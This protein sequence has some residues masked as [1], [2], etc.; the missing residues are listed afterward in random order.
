MQVRDT[1]C[2]FPIEASSIRVYLRVTCVC[3]D[4]RRMEVTGTTRDL[5]SE[6]A[7]GQVLRDLRE[8]K[9]MTLD[10]VAAKTKVP[11][12]SL[13]LIEEDDF[14]R[15]PPDVYTTIYLKA[16][17]KFFGI[18]AGP[19]V[20]HFRDQRAAHERKTPGNRHPVTTVKAAELLVAP[21][22]IRN[23][24]IAAVASGLLFSIAFQ[25][26]KLISPPQLTVTDPLDGTVTE[27]RSVTINGRTEPEVS[28][29]IN[30]K[31][32]SVD[33]NGVFH[34]TFI[35]QDGLNSIEVVGVKKYSRPM[36]VTRN[37]IVAAPP[38]A[39]EVTA[40]PAPDASPEVQSMDTPDA[41]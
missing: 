41:H 1:G 21:R 11:L 32:V 15:L 36:R 7:A 27:N 13:A 8:A 14:A 37:I 35:L 38:A 31:P 20:A 17:C 40:T 10:E 4:Q 22:I 33:G 5:V 23:V 2:T 12:Q 9:G 28:I 30:G 6:R 25:V 29:A 26:V 16:Y 24:I 19:I 3:T 34:D 39:P 18:E